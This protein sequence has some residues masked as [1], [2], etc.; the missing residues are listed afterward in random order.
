MG[1]YHTRSK[2]RFR[3]LLSVS[4]FLQLVTWILLITTKLF[5][6]VI[7][8][9]NFPGLFFVPVIMQFCVTASVL[10]F[11]NVSPSFRASAWHDRVIHCMVAAFCPWQYQMTHSGSCRI[12]TWRDSK[13]EI[14]LETVALQQILGMQTVA[15]KMM[16]DIFTLL[17]ASPKS[18]GKAKLRSPSQEL[19]H[20]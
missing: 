4:T 18:W 14:C 19:T 9:I 15:L 11:T 8:F 13:K 17:E 1:S 12:L 16:K 7:S 2:Q 10:S 20:F 3:R 5:I 6:Y